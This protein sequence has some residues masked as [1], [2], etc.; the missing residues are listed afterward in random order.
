MQIIKARKQD[1]RNIAELAMMAGE[2]IP[3]YFWSQSARDGQDLMEVGAQ[4]AA[5]ETENYSYRNVHIALIDGQIAGMMLAYRLPD[6]GEVEDLS[7]YPSFIR[8]LIELEQCVPASF[9]INMLATYP[10][11]RNRSVGTELMGIV[12]RLA[13][14]QQCSLSSIEVFEQN[15]GALRLYQRLG[16]KE[17]ERRKVIPHS[18]HPYDGD[19]VLLTRTATC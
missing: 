7:E 11:Y 14:E 6:T 12:D 18:C 10:V 9:Y 4:N 8:P 3:A 17:I 13:C 2:G 16:Y 19:I 15:V 5:S 1:C